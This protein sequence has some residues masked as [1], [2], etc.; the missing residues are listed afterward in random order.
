MDHAARHGTADAIRICRLEKSNIDATHSLCAIKPLVQNCESRPC[1][2]VDIIY[3]AAT[4]EV[5]KRA[6]AQMK[7]NM[8]AS[9]PA[10]QYEVFDAASARKEFLVDGDDVVGAIKYPAGSISA[11]K[12]GIGILKMGLEKGLNL[13]TYTPVTGVEPLDEKGREVNGE[14]EYSY[15]LNQPTRWMVHT[16][17]G[18]IRTPNLIVAANGYSAHLLPELL[19]NVVPY[20]GQIIAQT[21]GSTLRSLKPRGLPTTYSFIYGNGYEYMI[22]RPQLD[23]VPE[24]CKGD[25][26]IGGGIGKL[27]DDGVEEFGNT[28]DST[29]NSKNSPYLRKTNE[30]FFGSNWGPP[31][32]APV[33]KEWSGIMGATK[34]GAPFVGELPG[35]EGLWVSAGFNGQGMVLCFK[36]AEALVEMMFGAKVETGQKLDWF[37]RSFLVTK[38]RL[39]KGTFQGRKGFRAVEDNANV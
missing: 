22:Q 33:K 38:M 30:T 5:G 3:D 24:D 18:S 19:G 27:P 11:Y 9:D 20:R 32:E 2:T 14:S 25:I 35:A 16:D 17:R 13:Q 37:P 21:P 7:R 4:F 28:D 1:P 39:D 15:Q 6:V 10:A 31:E 12:F 29:M 23:A 26:V 36:C 34:D 8:G